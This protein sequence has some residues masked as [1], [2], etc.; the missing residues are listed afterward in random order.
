MERTKNNGSAK[1]EDQAVGQRMAQLQVLASMVDRI[2][3]ARQLGESY[4]GKR[5]IYEALGYPT[6][7]THTDYMTRYKRQDLAKALIDRPVKATWQGGV[8]VL[9][10]DD[11]R[12]TPFEKSWTELEEELGLMHKFSRLDRLACLG[13]YAVMLLGFDDVTQDTWH[14]PV[15]TG[16]RSL[17]YV[18]PLFQANAEIKTWET[19]PANPRYGM[20][21]HYSITL[22]KPGTANKDTYTLIVHYSRVLH[23]AMDLLDDEVEGEPILQA[24]FNRLIDLE[25]LVGGSAE[26]FWRGARPGY[27][28]KVDPDFKMTSAQEDELMK[29]LDEYEHNL[30][31]FLVAEGVD[32]QALASQIQDPS[33]HVDIQIQMISAMTGIP[34]RILTGSE[35]GELASSQDQETWKEMIQARREEQAEV[36]ILRPF[37][38][39]MVEVGVLPDYTDRYSIQWTDLFAPSDKDRAELGK[40]RMDAL[41]SYASEPGAEYFL[42]FEAFLQHMLGMDPAQI[43]LIKEQREQHLRDMVDEEAEEEPSPPPPP[44]EQEP[45]EEEEEEEE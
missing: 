39:R 27:Q 24:V 15:Q 16:T 17:L 44:T 3:L 6:A 21:R 23:V 31:R 40:I 22:T 42:P 19:D 38:E 28:G 4:G 36:V 29:Q 13:E 32:I 43:E 18:K 33:H 2:K 9:E 5:N 11:D 7:L 14:E 10:S 45:E 37:I 30:R 41:K 35:R 26:M 1:T 8:A 34:K 12:E 25:K 20:P